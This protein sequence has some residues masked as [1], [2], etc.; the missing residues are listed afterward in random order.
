MRSGN[1]RVNKLLPVKTQC[2]VH[3]YIIIIYTCTSFNSP[4][5]PHLSFPSLFPSSPPPPPSLSPPFSSP[6]SFPSLSFNPSLSLL[7]SLPL[8]PSIPPSLSP[9]IPPLSQIFVDQ[10]TEELVAVT[11][12]CPATHQSMIMVAHTSFHPPEHWATPT[13]TRLNTGYSDV[14]PLYVQGRIKVNSL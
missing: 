8:S 11:R 14:P 3:N 6:P 4:L 2:L 10:V 1:R 7:Q 13:S 5:F 12:H 9:S